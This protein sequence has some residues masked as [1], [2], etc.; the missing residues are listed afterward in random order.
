[1][2]GKDERPT[3][4]CSR[5]TPRDWTCGRSSWA[6]RRT[7]EVG[8]PVVAIGNP[9]GLD[10]TLT[11]GSCRALQRRLEAPNGFP[12]DDVIQTDAAINP[13]NS[14]GPLLDADG[15]VIGI[16]SQIATGGGGGSVGI[17]FAVPI[18]TAKQDPAAEAEGSVARLPRRHGDRSRPWLGLDGSRRPSGGLQV[19]DV[20]RGRPGEATGIRGGDAACIGGDVIETI[21]GRPVSSLTDLLSEVDRHEPGD[22]VTLSVLRNGTRGDVTVLLAERPATLAAG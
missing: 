10:R 7:V 16:N 1:M 15:R 4:R 17:G 20:Q 11:T 12:I 2:L 21:D 14:G 3:S 9:F 6:T 22:S 13:G 19:T 8:D 18:D 5:S